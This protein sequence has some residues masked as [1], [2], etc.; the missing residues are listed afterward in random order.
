MAGEISRLDRFIW[1][2]GVTTLLLTQRTGVELMIGETK[3]Y[4]YICLLMFIERHGWPS[5]IQTRI[6]PGT[7]VHHYRCGI[8]WFLATLLHFVALLGGWAKSL[9]P[10]RL[11]YIDLIFIRKDAGSNF[12]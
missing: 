12:R 9:W 8:L 5:E 4:L 1:V 10:N 6:L 7:G 11:V 3:V 2:L